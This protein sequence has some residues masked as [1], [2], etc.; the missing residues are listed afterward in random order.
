MTP[1]SLSMPKGE[2]YDHLVATATMTDGTTSDITDDATW[3]STNTS[4][5]TVSAGEVYGANVGNA[6]ITASYLNPGTSNAKVSNE[7]H[8]DVTDAIVKEVYITTSPDPVELPEGASK[9]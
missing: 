8:V 9:Q 3:D 6:V 5:A 4:I 7:V 1:P 2:R